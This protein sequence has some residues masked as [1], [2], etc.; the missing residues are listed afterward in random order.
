MRRYTLL[1]AAIL[2]LALVRNA[3]A[4]LITNLQLSDGTSNSPVVT[5]HYTNADG[6]GS[7]S[8]ATY[9]DPQISSGT[10]RPIFYCTDLWHDNYLGSTYTITQVPS[11]VFSA[12]AFSDVNNRIGWLLTQDQSTIDGRAAMQLAIWYTVDNVQNPHLAGFSYTGGDSFLRSDYNHLISFAGYNP[13]DHYSAKFWQATH[14][15][16]NTL[17][18]NLVSAPDPGVHTNA[19]VAEP[20]GIV[21]AGIGALC[22]IGA[23]LR[24]RASQPARATV[25]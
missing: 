18:Q 8:A 11:M 12:S 15:L 7:N 9:A 25:C 23:G 2:C 6:T 17:Y 5:V 10:S 1:S 20:S 21:L 24:R 19:V 3:H 13:G 14:D 16:S 4:D 22:L